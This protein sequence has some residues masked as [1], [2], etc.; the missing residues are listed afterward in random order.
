MSPAATA[1]AGGTGLGMGLIYRALVHHLTVIHLQVANVHDLPPGHR[2]HVELLDAMQV[3]ERE[4]EAFALR[5]RDEL[6]HIHG[7]N[8]LIALLIATTVAKGLPASGETGEEDIC[9]ELLLR[10]KAV[11]LWRPLPGNRGSSLSIERAD[12]CR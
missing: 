12:I 4:R 5:R 10:C 7:M 1:L 11:G 6:I 9:H 3:G 2:C 8:G